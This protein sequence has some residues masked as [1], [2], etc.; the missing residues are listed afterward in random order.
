MLEHQR[1]VDDS[2]LISDGIDEADAIIIIDLRMGSPNHLFENK[3]Y[4]HSTNLVPD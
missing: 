1:F 2:V 4:V 3:T